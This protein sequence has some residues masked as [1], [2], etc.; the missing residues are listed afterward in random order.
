MLLFNSTGYR[1]PESLLSPLIRCKF[2]LAIFCPNYVTTSL[3]NSS[4]NEC[5][6]SRFEG[7]FLIIVFP[8]LE[9]EF[10]IADMAHMSSSRTTSLERC[11]IHEGAWLKLYTNNSGSQNNGM[12]KFPTE[13]TSCISDAITLV[14]TKLEPLLSKGSLPLNSVTGNDSSQHFNHKIH[15]LVS[16]SLHLVGGVL[17]ILDPE[18]E[19]I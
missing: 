5:Q 11:Q 17:S 16:G 6:K 13:I 19:N 1:V 14:S 8:E 7:D 3:D 15:V 9:K 4:G 2:D 10:E 18:L 12:L